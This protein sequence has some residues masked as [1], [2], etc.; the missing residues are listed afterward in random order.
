MLMK[1]SVQKQDITMVS[2]YA[3]NIGVPKYINKM[4]TELKEETESKTIVVGDFNIRLTL[5]NRS[6]TQNK[7]GNIGIEWYTRTNRLHIYEQNST[8]MQQNTHFSPVYM[9]NYPK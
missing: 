7:N 1:G 9:K 8:Q 2:I 6:S 4:L 5:M 3:P